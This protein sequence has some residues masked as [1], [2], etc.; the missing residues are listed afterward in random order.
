MGLLRMIKIY[1]GTRFS[2]KSLVC[3]FPQIASIPKFL[4]F[5]S[6]PSKGWRLQSLL[7]FLFFFVCFFLFYV[8]LTFPIFAGFI[9]LA[10]K[11]LPSIPAGLLWLARRALPTTPIP[12]GLV[13]LCPESFANNSYSCRACL[14]LPGK[15]CQPPT[16]RRKSSAYSF[17][18]S[19]PP[20]NQRTLYCKI[21]SATVA[22]VR[23]SASQF[24]QFFPRS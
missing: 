24:L 15:L 10:R 7:S 6:F 22:V 19:H 12:A 4:P 9:W 23:T 13:W 14:A 16:F 21:A 5:P 3:S 1:L 20:K 11:A 2:A 17:R 18:P 8:F